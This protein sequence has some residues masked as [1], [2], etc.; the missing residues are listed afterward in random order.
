VQQQIGGELNAAIADAAV[1]VHRRALG[2]GPTRAQAFY[3][4]DVVVLVLRDPLTK[5]ERT[6]V[7]H[8]CAADALHIRERYQRAMREQLVEAVEELTGRRVQT[9]ICGADVDPDVVA[10]VFVLDE[11]V[12]NGHGVSTRPDAAL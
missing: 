5:A 4:D 12:Q 11:P 1:R 6:L 9:F 8:G 7:D 10:Q 2:R 3:R